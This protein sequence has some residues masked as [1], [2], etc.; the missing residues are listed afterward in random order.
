MVSFEEKIRR[1]V[2]LPSYYSLTYELFH[3]KLT[4]PIIIWYRDKSQFIIYD[5]VKIVLRCPM[6]LY[7]TLQK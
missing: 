3:A 7:S 5:P 2:P 6:F 4:E 1:S